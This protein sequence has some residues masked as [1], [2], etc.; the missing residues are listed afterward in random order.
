M[1]WAGRVEYMRERRGVR[2]GLEGKPTGK[3]PLG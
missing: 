2:R 1:R 3:R